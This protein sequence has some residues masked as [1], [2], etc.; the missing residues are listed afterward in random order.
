[1]VN[2]HT[3]VFPIMATAF[4]AL[5]ASKLVCRQPIYWSLAEEFLA[6]ETQEPAPP[7]M[8]IQKST[9][10]LSSKKRAGNK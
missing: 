4:I 5:A 1:M 6:N 10:A 7:L 9:A 2:D 3:M 8:Q